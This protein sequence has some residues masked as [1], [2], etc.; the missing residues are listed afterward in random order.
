MELV[1]TDVAEDRAGCSP[2]ESLLV[3]AHSASE[4]CSVM[5]ALREFAEVERGNGGRDQWDVN[6]SS[7][8]CY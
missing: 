2:A 1:K 5:L 3:A 4:A 7:G 6:S 8:L